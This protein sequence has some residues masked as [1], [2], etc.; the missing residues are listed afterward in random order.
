[1]PL[2]NQPPKSLLQTNTS[3]R[4]QVRGG[5]TGIRETRTYEEGMWRINNLEILAMKFAFQT[6]LKDQNL[7]S[8]SNGKNNSFDLP[9]K[10]G[11]QRI[12]K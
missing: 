10:W 5:T 12:K 3:L 4:R 6:F 7:T 8:Y 2:S 9:K 11:M 1:M